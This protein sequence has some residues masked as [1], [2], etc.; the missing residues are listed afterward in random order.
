[1]GTL[2]GAAYRAQVAAANE[3]WYR[4]PTVEGVDTFSAFVRSS[5]SGWSTGFAIPAS[6]VLENAKRTGWVLGGLALLCI[7]LAIIAAVQ[8]GRRIAARSGALSTRFQ[9]SAWSADRNRNRDPRSEGTR[10]AMRTVSAAIGERHRLSELERKVL[11][12][13]DRA[14]DEFLA[15]LSHELRNPLA[16]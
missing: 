12:D 3:G 1:V 6:V 16:R 15:M 10:G 14:K 8:V 7:G 2:A 9:R 5:Y 11:A 13:S 4:G